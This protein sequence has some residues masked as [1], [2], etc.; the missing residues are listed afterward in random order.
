MRGT[1]EVKPG[2]DADLVELFL[3]VGI[4]SLVIAYAWKKGIFEWNRKNPMPKP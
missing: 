1:A 2:R 3:F 4:L